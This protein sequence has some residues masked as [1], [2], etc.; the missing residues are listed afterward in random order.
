MTRVDIYSG[1]LGA[2]KTT[3]IKKLIKEAYNN[4]K[5]VLVENEFGKV[6]IDSGFLKDTGIEITAMSSGCICCSLSG[7]FKKS[8]KKIQADYN[9]DRI[10]IE[11]TGVGALSTVV[12]S[13]MEAGLTV[14]GLTTVVDVTKCKKY[15]KN[16]GE[17]F[18]DQVETASVIMLSRTKDA[19]PELV[20]DVVELL[21]MKNPNATIITTDWDELDGKKIL[22]IIE[23][24]DMLKEE[25]EKLVAEHEH[26]CDD[27]NCSCH[28]HDHDDDDDEHEHHHHHHHS[29]EADAVFKSW[30]K[31]TAR[32]YS[33]DDI[34]AAL[35]ALDDEEKFGMVLRAKGILQAPDNS[36]IHFDYTPG[37]IDIRKGTAEPTGMICVIGHKLNEEAVTQLW[38]LKQVGKKNGA[39]IK[40]RSS[41]L[42]FYWIY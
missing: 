29:H 25:L 16:F 3:L 38:G 37:E 12:D 11:P 18:G 15:L 20:A 6:G 40:K 24:R 27:P 19:D 30:G 21:Q 9:P 13:V 34:K 2:G 23:G 26:E 31:E 32:K 28:D 35:T 1:F 4:E 7:D 41:L 5:I 17:F 39:G 10:L 33:E 22:E 42:P 8:I 14:G 36:W